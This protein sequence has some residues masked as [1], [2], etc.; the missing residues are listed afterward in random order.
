MLCT[1]HCQTG[2]VSCKPVVPGRACDLT[3]MHKKVHFK[4]SQIIFVS[5]SVQ[6]LCDCIERQPDLALLEL[7]TELR[8]VCG[9]ETS[10]QAVVH[11]LQ[12][13]TI[14]WIISLDLSLFVDEV[15]GCLT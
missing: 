1:T 15:F 9:M 8:E 7:Q 5:Q 2:E 10:V 3:S 13:V 11:T 6:F 14:Q 12:S 4:V